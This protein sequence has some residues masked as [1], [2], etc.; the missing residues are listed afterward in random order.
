[1]KGKFLN[2]IIL[3]QILSFAFND[4][5]LDI[6]RAKSFSD[7]TGSLTPLVVSLSSEDIMDKVKG[8][9]L[10]CIVD[11]SGSMSGSPIQLVKDSL[12]YLVNLMNEQDNVALVKFESSATVLYDFT[13]MT[14]SNKQRLVTTIN[15]LYA[16]G[17][18]NIYGA[19][20]SALDLLK[21][22]YLTGDRIAS[23]IL[24][25]DGGDNYYGA[26]QLSSLFKELLT[27]TGKDSYAFTLHTF[28]F[29]D[30]HDYQ[31]MK[32]LATIKGGRYFS[33]SRLLDVNDA[34]L[35]IYGGLSTVRNVNLELEIKSNFN[36]DNVFGM[37][38]MYKSSLSNNV[39]KTT[40][41][42]VIYG[43]QY[44]FLVFVN[45]P[46]N[47]ARGTE[48][49][50]AT[51]SPL[52]KT[53]VYLWDNVYDSVAYEEYI[54]SICVN[55]FSKG[56]DIIIT[57]GVSQCIVILQ[58]GRTW[59][60][61]N[62]SGKKEWIKEFD[63]I[64]NDLNTNSYS[65]TSLLLSKI[66]EYRT[67]TIG[68]SNSDINTYTH[69]IVYNSHNLDVSKL[70]TMRVTGT[71]LI[72][73]NVN[74]NY[75]FFYLKE[76]SGV[77]DNMRFSGL[78]S[79][80]ILYSDDPTKKINITSL[81]GY[82]DYYYVSEKRTQI[83]TIVD[84]SRGG[85]FIIEKD[86][87]Y[88]F[89]SYVDGTR[90]IT[91]NIEFLKIVINEISEKVEHLFE[92]LAYIVSEAD[93][94]NHY[95]PTTSVYN[96]TYDSS[97][98]L[99][100]IV[101]SKEEIK[102]YLT[103]VSYSYLYIVVKK[104]NVN[105]IYKHVEGQFIFVSMDNIH[106]IIPE[107]FFISSF[108]TVGQRTPH[109]YTLAGKNMTV[110]FSSPGDELTCTILKYLIYQTGSEEVFVDYRNFY[111]TRRIENNKVYINIVNLDSI[112]KNE[113]DN[114]IIS[115]FSKN[116]GHIAG[117]DRTKLTYAIKYY[118]NPLNEELL[119]RPKATLVL[120]GFAKFVHIRTIKICS[121][122]VYF[123]RI[124]EI[125]YSEII[126]IKVRIKYKVTSLR[127]LEE[128]TK[129]AECKLTP[130]DFDNQNR[131]NCTVETNGEEIESFEVDNNVVFPDQMVDIKANTPIASKQMNNLQ[132]IGD[133]D[134]F[135]KQLFILDNSTMI[136]ED[137]VL[138]ITGTINNKSFNYEN[139]NL[140]LNTENSN[141]AKNISCKIIKLNEEN[142]TL[143]CNPNGEKNFKADSAFADLGNDNLLI[144]F[145]D[146]KNSTEVSIDETPIT[147]SG[148]INNF[149]SK[150]GKT[151]S[152]GGIVGI[153]LASV[154]ALAIVISIIVCLRSR[155]NYS[156]VNDTTVTVSNVTHP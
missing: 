105:I 86:F 39:F 143:Q 77:I 69:S 24:L 152:A 15:G 136:I 111:I 78:G 118:I 29:G 19:L 10:I 154:A 133:S 65:G 103:S 13:K 112:Q 64:I 33:I 145:V 117:S 21:S 95:I 115:I 43:M 12:K 80:F 30:Y 72:E 46:E 146:V 148:G 83:Q 114:L 2:I 22:N 7:Q 8:V 140:S 59:I 71:K 9:D 1:M 44:S 73:F 155:K 18:T 138:N 48:V 25:S 54:K 90:D 26:E 36:I 47:T 16:S 102:R 56:Y 96:G 37:E 35:Q 45:V 92:I 60:L 88:E 156:N 151:L 63:V 52:G 85:K 49:L 144:N 109:L 110:E 89:Y 121:F 125:V 34:Y 126:T 91:F 150:K 27:T 97:L 123:A 98:S 153:V 66:H 128:S 20:Q 76:G 127:V 116:T 134:I 82:I 106:S 50:R 149:R 75:Y 147:T 55:Y 5:T 14:E 61:N 120:L 108:L 68:T 132:N 99:G 137:N 130:S 23:M 11:V 40:L 53:A 79:C 81:N 51:V 41:I 141:E 104:I 57:Q 139:I 94:N 142:Y 32:Q 93:I 28:G 6:L 107:G 62:Y 124:R 87:P 113:T 100:K 129:D 119:K 4:L 17:G 101:I 74:I 135:N 70:P 3:I 31:L 131:Y 122:F 38:D 58:E 84:F 67:S 42:Q